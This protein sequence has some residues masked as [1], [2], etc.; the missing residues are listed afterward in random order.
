[1]IHGKTAGCIFCHK[2]NEAAKTAKAPTACKECHGGA[3]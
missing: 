1:M 3:E 2:T